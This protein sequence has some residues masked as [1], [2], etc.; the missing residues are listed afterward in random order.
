MISLDTETTGVDFHHGARPFFV[1]MCNEVGDQVY[2][3]WDVDPLTRQPI[4]PKDDM[5]TIS[6]FL[7][8]K[9]TNGLVL[10]N[11]KFDVTALAWR[12]SYHT[13]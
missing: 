11:A 3:E 1:T 13:T 10:Q 4:I 12:A 9:T 2:Y 5:E 6:T 7:L 8:R